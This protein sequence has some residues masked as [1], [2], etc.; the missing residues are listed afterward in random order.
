MIYLLD[1]NV[2]H[3]H[4]VVMIWAFDVLSTEGK[5]Q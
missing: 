1:F 5:K 3:I 4:Y 2:V